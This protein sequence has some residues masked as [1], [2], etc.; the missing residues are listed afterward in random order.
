MVI[1]RAQAA[2]GPDSITSNS[3]ETN[4]DTTTSLHM[5]KPFGF[6]SY[7]SGG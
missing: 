6:I 5:Y 1:N 3:K 2:T 7:T 4:A